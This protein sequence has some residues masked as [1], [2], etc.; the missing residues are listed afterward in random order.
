MDKEVCM[1]KKM[2]TVFKPSEVLKQKAV[3]ISLTLK[4][5]TEADHHHEC[6]VI[7]CSPT[8]FRQGSNYFSHLGLLSKCSLKCVLKLYSFS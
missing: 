7:M 3:S 8:G 5:T 4:Q 2:K 1:P 6:V